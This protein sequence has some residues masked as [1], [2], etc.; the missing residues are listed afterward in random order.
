MDWRPC[1]EEWS[2]VH[3]G[4][5]LDSPVGV[6]HPS[7]LSPLFL[8]AI[9]HRR[10]SPTHPGAFW[11]SWFHASSW[12][13]WSEIERNKKGTGLAKH[14]LKQN[15]IWGADSLCHASTVMLDSKLSSMKLFRNSNLRWIR[16]EDQL[17]TR[18][19]NPVIRLNIKKKANQ[20]YRKHVSKMV[21]LN[22]NWQV[23][24]LASSEV[25]ASHF[26]ST[27]GGHGF[28]GLRPRAANCLFLSGY[29]KSW[30]FWSDR[31]ASFCSSVKALILFPFPPAEVMPSRLTLERA[32]P[33][34]GLGP[35]LLVLKWRCKIP[36]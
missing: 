1:M 31:I 27:P 12:K 9:A 10:F 19:L 20:L 34:W 29:G 26:A 32:R 35:V 4:L 2:N 25:A 5:V 15:Q 16:R 8:E 6:A 28:S 21:L 23:S 18:Q 30:G 7:E 14:V 36:G 17:D 11:S 33:I 13:T 22:M 3:L 24:S